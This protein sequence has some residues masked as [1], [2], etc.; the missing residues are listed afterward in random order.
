MVVPQARGS[1]PNASDHA[2]YSQR[3]FR[4]RQSEDT[5]PTSEDH[6]ST[7]TLTLRIM[8]LERRLSTERTLDIFTMKSKV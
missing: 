3:D 5:A 8:D 7:S 1:L 4:D 2:V 6:M